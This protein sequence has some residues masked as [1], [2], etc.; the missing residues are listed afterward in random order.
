[1]NYLV[2][3]TNGILYKTLISR[4]PDYPI[5]ELELPE[6]DGRLFLDV[7]CS[8][9][10]WS[11]AAARK[12]YSPVGIDPSLG[13]VMAGK[14][15]AAQLDLPSRF[16]VG[17]ARHLP[18]RD[19]AIDTVFSYSVIQ[20]FSYGDADQ[21]I[22]EAARV[23]VPSGT[24]LIQL[25]N[26]FGLRCLYHQARRAFRAPRAFEVRYW[27]PKRIEQ[28]F[29]QLFKTSVLSPDCF[30]GIGLQASDAEMMP[31][32][33]RLVIQVSEFA[34]RLSKRFPF[35]ARTADSIWIRSVAR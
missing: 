16:L 17:D 19:Q 29:G 9:G 12:G 2:A 28:K 32:V 25:P 31:R 3:A 30:F 20:H 7:G 11:I 13:A 27:T 6:G 22:R 10:R 14:R 35:L 8:W 15:V 24:C 21:S 1:M 18:F 26:T 33:R 4:L 23:L 34:K 5:P